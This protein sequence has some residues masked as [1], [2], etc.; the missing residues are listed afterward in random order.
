MAECFITRRSGSNSG[1]GLTADSAFVANSTYN[2]YTTSITIDPTKK[3]VISTFS[4]Y[5]YSDDYNLGGLSMWLYD[6]GTI[7]PLGGR[8]DYLYSSG[9]MSIDFKSE[10]SESGYGTLS[11]SG[12]TL[13]YTG[14]YTSGAYFSYPAA[15]IIAVEMT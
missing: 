4:G 14:N 8:S 15:R 1:G 12:S 7:S 6:N 3:Y 2:T 11:I 5:G 9:Y 13:T 10:N